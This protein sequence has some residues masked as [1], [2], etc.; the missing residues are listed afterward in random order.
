MS[1]LNKNIFFSLHAEFSELSTWTLT[2]C[3]FGLVWVTVLW[4]IVFA[5][6]CPQK[7]SSG[8]Y[9]ENIGPN[10]G[11]CVPC[12]CNGL[13][14]VCDP[15]T[16]NCE[17]NKRHACQ[18]L[19]KEDSFFLTIK[20]CYILA[21]FF[22]IKEHLHLFHFTKLFGHTGVCCLRTFL[23]SRRPSELSAQHH[24]GPLWAL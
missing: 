9:R 21:P 19:M 5:S 20:R 4:M 15:H 10:I 17:V 14:S 7:C 11:Q 23:L 22:K 8:F 1:S 24:W 12:S 13:S 16:G 2:K 3:S 6:V 18:W